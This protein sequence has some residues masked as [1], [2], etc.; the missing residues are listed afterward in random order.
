MDKVDCTNT[1]GDQNGNHLKT[2]QVQWW[3]KQDGGQKRS[4]N[5]KARLNRTI[6][7]DMNQVHEYQTILILDIKLPGIQM[8]L[9]FKWYKTAVTLHLKSEPF[10]IF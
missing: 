5:Y 1:V 6:F 8:V 3:L 7:I 9:V 2:G 10:K 4:N